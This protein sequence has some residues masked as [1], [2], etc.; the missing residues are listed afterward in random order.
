MTPRG[1]GHLGRGERRQGKKTD[2]DALD[3]VGTILALRYELMRVRR[4]WPGAVRF[5]Y[6]DPDTWNSALVFDVSHPI[7]I[8]QAR[9]STLFVNVM[10]ALSS[11]EEY[12]LDP[13]WP[14]FDILT[15]LP[16]VDTGAP[17]GQV[18]RMIELKSSTVQARKQSMTWNEWK[19]AAQSTLARVFWLYL[20]G[21][22]RADLHGVS[23]YLQMVKDPFRN[24]RAR[25]ATEVS[26]K[27]KVDVYTA[28]FS[29]ARRLELRP[30]LR[31][32]S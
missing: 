25:A 18:D 5:R 23:P 21:N 2:L 16:E 6:E 28:H 24:I 10:A 9:K 17:A 31:S 20:I 30:N 22:L 26:V 11:N 32:R 12:G 7:K 13:G 8:E 1:S 3:Q 29:E 27:R 15:L 4:S 19:T 14:G